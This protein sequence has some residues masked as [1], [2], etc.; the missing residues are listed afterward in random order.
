M[1]KYIIVF[2]DTPEDCHRIAIPTSTGN[3][4]IDDDINSFKTVTARTLDNEFHSFRRVSK[5]KVRVL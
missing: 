3:H 1:T 4:V 5:A 2:V